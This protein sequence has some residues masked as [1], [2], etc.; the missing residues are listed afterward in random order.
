MTD[1]PTPYSKQFDNLSFEEAYA[2]LEDIVSQLESGKLSLE[3]SV[4]LFEHGRKLAGYCQSVL[5]GA[6]LRVNQLADDG[7][8]TDLL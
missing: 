5:D 6:E 7:T 4:A 8:L 1:T 2:E 3:Q